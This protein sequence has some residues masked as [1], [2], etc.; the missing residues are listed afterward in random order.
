MFCKV[1]RLF[2]SPSTHR[3]QLTGVEVEVYFNFEFGWE[4]RGFVSGSLLFVL[5]VGEV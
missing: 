2:V 4:G 3:K 1:S 5:G